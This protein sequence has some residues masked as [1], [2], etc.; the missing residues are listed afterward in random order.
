MIP[1]IIGLFNSKSGV[2]TT[3]VVYH[4]AHIFSKM[5]HSVLAI[6]LDPQANLTSAFFDEMEMVQQQ[7]D[8]KT[9]FACLEPMIN[10]VGDI[11]EPQPIKIR[12]GLFVIDGDLHLNFFENNLIDAWQKHYEGKEDALRITTA[13]Y[14]IM[15]SGA[16]KCGAEIILVD[17]GPNLG[18]INRAAILSMDYLVSPITIDLFSMQGTQCGG[19][20]VRSWQQNWKTIIQK[21]GKGL[22]I[23]IPKGE[24]TPIGYV[25]LHH[26]RRQSSSLNLCMQYAEG[27]TGVEASCAQQYRQS[28]TNVFSDRGIEFPDSNCLG[29]LQSYCSLIPMA[30][31]VLKPVFDLLPA[32][33][34]IGGYT[35]LVGIAYHEFKA[36]AENIITRTSQNVQ[37]E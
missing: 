19:A 18:A 31:E 20:Y 22:N 28:F 29:S 2:G 8:H 35:N 24:V 36:L 7:L 33:G 14:R 17:V 10:G 1:K 9:I 16:E 11:Q 3:T 4:L 34:A 37:P 6:D 21:Q 25:F 12:D 15:L 32:D 5:G 30:Q 13:F 26:A 27:I 23:P